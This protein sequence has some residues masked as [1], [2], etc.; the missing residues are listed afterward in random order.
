MKPSSDQL[1]HKLFGIEQY[2]DIIVNF[3]TQI[4][5]FGSHQKRLLRNGRYNKFYSEKSKNDCNFNLGEY[6]VCVDGSMKQ[7]LLSSTLNY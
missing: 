1:K 6:F 3:R 4:E 5:N 7:I 2:N